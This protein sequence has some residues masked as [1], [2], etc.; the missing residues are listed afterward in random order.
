MGPVRRNPVFSDRR[1]PVMVKSKRTSS[2]SGRKSTKAEGKKPGKASLSSNKKNQKKTSKRKN[3]TS[4]AEDDEEEMDVDI[5][6][7]DS[8]ASEGE[9][10]PQ[11]LFSMNR[12]V[13]NYLE[14]AKELSDTSVSHVLDNHGDSDPLVKGRVL[15]LE[16]VGRSPFDK[17][18]DI[19]DHQLR[20]IYDYLYQAQSQFRALPYMAR[21][22]AVNAKMRT[23][24]VDWLAEVHHKFKLQPCTLWLTVNILDR[25]LEK[26]SVKR[27]KLQ[28]VGVTSLFIAC[29]CYNSQDGV[30]PGVMESVYITDN[31]YT[32]AEVT[33]TEI[34]I[35]VALDFEVFVPTGYHFLQHYLA[36]INAEPLVRNLARFYAERNLQEY[37]VLNFMPYHFAAAAVYAALVYHQQLYQTQSDESPVSEHVWPPELERET[38]LTEARLVPVARTLLG[39]VNESP[40]TSR[41]RKLNSVWKKYAVEK[42]YAVA[43]LPLPSI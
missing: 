19:P 3:R 25:Y 7:G 22:E 27:V 10:E 4:L 36:I 1:F 35:L 24:L 23:I 9:E 26:E 31:A 34:K 42:Y 16:R 40:S 14:N 28:L 20:S 43:Q 13:W 12:P 39:H 30:S 5:R 17:N 2:T 37:D 15:R 29:K 32:P 33:E 41:S 8:D 18:Y 21:Q 6:V 11:K 38:G